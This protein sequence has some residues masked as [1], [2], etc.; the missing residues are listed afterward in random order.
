MSI[1][2]PAGR[3]RWLVGLA[4]LL[5]ASLLALQ[6]SPAA[7]AAERRA[8]VIVQM[9][10]GV[11]LQAGTAGVRRLGGRVTGRLPIINGFSATIPARK[12][13]RLA[14]MPGV[15]AVTVNH[16]VASTSISTSRLATAYP[17]SIDA[18]EAWNR[19]DSEVTG[20]G[21]GV[22]VIDT[23]IA[24]GMK[25]FERAGRSKD[26][27]VVA[28]VVTNPFATSAA[29]RYG[30]GTHVAGIL[31]GNGNERSND[32]PLDGRY[33]GVAPEA[34]LISIKASDDLGKA[35][36]LDVIYGL[37]FVVDNKDAYNI[38]V[39]NLSLEST[40][41]SSYKTDPLAAAA[42]AAWFKGIVVVAA[43]G[44]RGTAADAVQYAP[45]NDPYVITVGAIDDDATRADVDDFR[46]RWSSR[47]VTQDGIAK[48][49][50]HA[51]GARIVSTL[52]PNSAF[53]G[54]CPTCIVSGQMIRAGG[55]SMSAPMVSG[56]VALL[57]E[58]HPNLTPN[59][60]KGVLTASARLLG[61]R[62]PEVDAY[63][64]I[65]MVS[66]G[67][68]PTANQGLAPNSIVD[69][70]TGEIDYSRSSWSRSSWS[71]AGGGLTA[72]WARS[73]WSCNCSVDGS[74]QVLG[75]RSSWS[76]SSWSTSWDK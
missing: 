50:I 54:M 5:C 43:A 14:A 74:G 17:S 55:T 69:P 71:T 29:D 62:V 47:G 44:N 16:G 63:A 18:I 76:L 27:R 65:R 23:G 59:Q 37:Q 7:G 52:A 53:A 46:P 13:P 19:W 24:G 20:R 38:R 33:V 6:S 73:S 25:D 9:D 64:A 2:H 68:V 11:K 45:G 35:T 36:V 41:P 70:A 31:A 58:K 42:E 3:I 1:P 40:V 72:D 66:S 56:A 28:S 61:G 10:A 15:R 48:P 39:V 75:S 32:D 21:V 57:L 51:P 67:N 8:T 26:S 4:A 60:V 49:E 30:H 12:K 34:D 22:A